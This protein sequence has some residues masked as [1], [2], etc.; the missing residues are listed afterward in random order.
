MM[1][2]ASPV[3]F[4]RASEAPIDAKLG[5][6]QRALDKADIK[7][8]TVY[9]DRSGQNTAD[10]QHHIFA[11][12]SE[13]DSRAKVL[14][15]LACFNLYAL[16]KLLFGMR[17]FRTIHAIDLDSGV[18]AV[19]ASKVTGRRLVYDIYD[20]F[21]DSRGLSGKT[22]QLVDRLEAFVIRHA[23]MVIIADNCRLAQ[24]P[25]IEASKL[26]VVENIPET[27]VQYHPLS[28]D[29]QIA[30]RLIKVGYLGT[31]EPEHRGLE[32]LC[33]A[34]TRL[35]FVELYIAGAGALEP[36][37]R[38]WAAGCPRIKFLGP[39][40]HH[41]GLALMQQ[42][43]IIA[44]LYY[45]SQPNHAFA[46]PNKYFEHLLLGRPLLTSKGTPPGDKVEANNSGWAVDDNEE[47][48]AA[49]LSEAFADPKLCEQLG[50]NAR[51]LWQDNFAQYFDRVY[52]AEFIDRLG[53][54]NSAAKA[55]IQ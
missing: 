52:A 26:L 45:R 37:V 38:Q 27:E 19:L 6:Y 14:L 53:K 35:D 48:I 44:G 16:A 13:G 51:H 8:L 39:Q 12:R 9:W 40:S 1:T 50:K 31:L 32:H 20:S 34:V 22:K 7:N 42:C 43:D 54:L 47:S 25:P 30:N 5:R 11:M 23:D 18:C 55:V 10:R 2:A 49:A 24:H 4:L 33:A 3:I 41:D 36:D 21:A 17:E 29:N 46:A 28:N 15:K